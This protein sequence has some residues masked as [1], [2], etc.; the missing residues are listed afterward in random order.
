MLVEA[1]SGATNDVQRFLLA[2]ISS[3]TS[4]MHGMDIRL[5][6]DRGLK[7]HTVQSVPCQFIPNLFMV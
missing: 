4:E 5:N 1:F 3:A 7:K 2:K 6:E